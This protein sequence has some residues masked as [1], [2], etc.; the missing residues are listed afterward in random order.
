MTRQLMSCA[1]CHGQM[2]REDWP[3]ASELVCI[4]CGYRIDT[5]A[6]TQQPVAVAPTEERRAA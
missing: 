2:V 5:R 3:G 4:Q 6:A 1:R